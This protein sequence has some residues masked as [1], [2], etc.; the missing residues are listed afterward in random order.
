MANKSE[1]LIW[2]TEA[3]VTYGHSRNWFNKR[4]ADGVFQTV[5][6]PGTPKV[7]LRVS[8]IDAYLAEHPEE[9]SESGKVWPQPSR[10]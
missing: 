2:I 5:P 7:F 4:I 9:R 10:G 3:M 1:E 8:E 6:Q